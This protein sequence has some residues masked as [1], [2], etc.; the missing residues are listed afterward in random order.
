MFR[1][2]ILRSRKVHGPDHPDT[3]K[4]EFA[5]VKALEALEK[6]SC[7]TGILNKL[8]SGVLKDEPGQEYEPR[9]RPG[10]WEGYLPEFAK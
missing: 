10:P 2:V 6:T 7:E 9:A 8:C 4:S 3:H 1:D 5:F